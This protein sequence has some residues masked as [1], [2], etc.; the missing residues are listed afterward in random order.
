MKKAQSESRRRVP[1]TARDLSGEGGIRTRGGCN[2]TR[3]FQRC[4]STFH[5]PRLRSQTYSFQLLIWSSI[6]KPAPS[7]GS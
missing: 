3:H 2:T 4:M 5:H 1:S 6:C 7:G